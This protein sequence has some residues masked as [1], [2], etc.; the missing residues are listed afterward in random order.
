MNIFLIVYLVLYYFS[1]FMKKK[2]PKKHVWVPTAKPCCFVVQNINKE[3]QKPISSFSS[4]F[5]SPYPSKPRK[6]PPSPSRPSK[7]NLHPKRRSIFRYINGHGGNW[8]L[9]CLISCF[10]LLHFIFSQVFFKAIA[11]PNAFFSKKALFYQ[12][13][14]Y[15]FPLYY[16]F[17]CLI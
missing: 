14:Q 9:Q 16:L 8:N 7:E 1:L 12:N 4:D 17:F 3:K 15:I 10:H 13:S 6:C 5:P 11:S 2:K